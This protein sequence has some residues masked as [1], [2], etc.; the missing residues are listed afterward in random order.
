MEAIDPFGCKEGARIRKQRMGNKMNLFSNYHSLKAFND[1]TKSILNKTETA[2]KL[3]WESK[4]N[5]QTATEMARMTGWAEH[6][7]CSPALSRAFK[8][9][10]DIVYRKQEG[11]THGRYYCRVFL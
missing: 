10:D 3:I 6:K 1:N 8:N 5:G 11:E 9:D 7:S 4:G 2:T